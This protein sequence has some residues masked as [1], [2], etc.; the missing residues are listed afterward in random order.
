[1][2]LATL[3]TWY[4]R[5]GIVFTI[6]LAKAL[7]GLMTH[8][9]RISGSPTLEEWD[10][11]PRSEK[12]NEDTAWIKL[13]N[14]WAAHRHSLTEALARDGEIGM[15]VRVPPDASSSSRRDIDPTA[16]PNEVIEEL[17]KAIA[18]RLHTNV[19]TT[20]PTDGAE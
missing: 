9:H 11:R 13:V 7:A 10:A 8:L 6:I 16:I 3:K 17:L 2:M 18:N 15:I 1:M 14:S 4:M 19:I 12:P 5:V 20:S